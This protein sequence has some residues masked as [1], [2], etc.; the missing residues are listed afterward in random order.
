M[1]IGF[2]SQEFID[3]WGQDTTKS[4]AW[5]HRNLEGNVLV[6]EAVQLLGRTTKGEMIINALEMQVNSWKL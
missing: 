1:L 4:V 2:I 3:S 6:Y 5:M